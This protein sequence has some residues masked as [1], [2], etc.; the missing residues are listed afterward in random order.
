MVQY[1]TLTSE[2]TSFFAGDCICVAVLPVFL[3]FGCCRHSVT[4]C[5]VSAERFKRGEIKTAFSDSRFK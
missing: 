4:R 5:L 3:V 1:L 2:V